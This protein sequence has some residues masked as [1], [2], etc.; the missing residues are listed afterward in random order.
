VVKTH[1]STQHGFEH[2]F[3]L[4]TQQ[5]DKQNV[6]M[7]FNRHKLLKK[8]VSMPLSSSG[9]PSNLKPM[10]PYD[11]RRTSEI[12]ATQQAPSNGVQPAAPQGLGPPPGQQPLNYVPP[13]P[14]LPGTLGHAATNVIDRN[15]GLD[16]KGRTYDG[17]NAISPGGSIT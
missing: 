11:A 17:N 7:F 12:S 2:I 10:K 13:T 3:D 8:A 5:M 6:L 14:T 4:L 15:G 9:V 16:P 1:K